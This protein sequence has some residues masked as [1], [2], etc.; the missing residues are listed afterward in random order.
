MTIVTQR[1]NVEVRASLV[2]HFLA[3]PARD[4]SLRFGRSLAPG[5]IVDY[6]NGIDFDRDAVFG[7]HDDRLA[8][9]AAAH[10]AFGDDTA[11]LGLSVLPEHRGHGVGRALFERAVAHARNRCIPRLFMHFLT[12]NEPIMRMARRF[13][14]DIV[15]R[16]G[17]ADAHLALPPASLVSIAGEFVTE[18]FARCDSALRTLVTSWKRQRRRGAHSG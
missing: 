7:V 11:E 9:V 18:T 1:M 17:E 12:E 10:V 6:V 2:A 13:R 5:A 4:R 16:A 15:A 8:L 14:M 3:L